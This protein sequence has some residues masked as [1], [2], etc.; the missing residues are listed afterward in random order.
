M[1]SST[2]HF[3]SSLW[4]QKLTIILLYFWEDI[5]GWLLWTA[6]NASCNRDLFRCFLYNF[7]IR[8]W[9][10]LSYNDHVHPFTLTTTPSKKN[11]LSVY[12]CDICQERRNPDHIIYSF[13]ECLLIAHFE[14]ILPKVCIGHQLYFVLWIILNAFCLRYW[15]YS[16][17]CIFFK[18]IGWNSYLAS[19]V[20]WKNLLLLYIYIYG[21]SC[22]NSN[23]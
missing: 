15:L 16:F 23:N 11:I 9:C 2:L 19:C 17:I 5:F 13:E 8:S 7:N 6:C 4:N 1:P 10:V 22:L 3:W 18:H 12:F 20:K 14:C 21:V